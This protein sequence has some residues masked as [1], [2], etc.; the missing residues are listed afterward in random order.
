MRPLAILMVLFLVSAWAAEQVKKPE[1]PSNVRR[2]L[3]AHE[4]AL[5]KAQEAY[6][7]AKA[8]ADKV[9]LKALEDQFAKYPNDI[10][11]ALDLKPTQEQ[12]D[13][14]SVMGLAEAYEVKKLIEGMSL[15][16]QH[17]DV[18]AVAA[19][20]EIVGTWITEKHGPWT[21]SIG[22]NGDLELANPNSRSLAYSKANDAHVFH[23]GNKN[24]VMVI[25]RDGMLYV[26]TCYTAAAQNGFT[27]AVPTTK[28]S[29]VMTMSKKI[30]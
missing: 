15:K 30:E 1:L 12:I 20:P 25:Q 9:A 8:E 14:S 4:R 6:D 28:T 5:A 23:W 7:K 13:Q 26:L 10:K 19:L 22:N 3:E 24:D 17:K 16:I 29:W 27:K 21:V 18:P 11:L 2:A